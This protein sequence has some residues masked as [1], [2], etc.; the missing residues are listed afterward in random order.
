MLRGMNYEEMY[1]MLFRD[2]IHIPT[3]I[4]YFMDLQKCAKTECHTECSL[5]VFI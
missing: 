1:G 4:F 3:M 5:Y 2:E